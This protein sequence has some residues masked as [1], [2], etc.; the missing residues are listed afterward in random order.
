MLEAEIDYEGEDE[1]DE[2]GSEVGLEGEGGEGGDIR[3]KVEGERVLK[4]GY[5]DKKGE[6]RKVSFVSLPSHGC[7]QGEAREREKTSAAGRRHFVGAPLFSPC[8]TS[9]HVYTHPYYPTSVVLSFNSL[10]PP[11]SSTSP[12]FPSC[13]GAT[14]DRFRP[15]PKLARPMLGDVL[16]GGR[17]SGS[18]GVEGSLYGRRMTR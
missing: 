4:S 11:F 16:L 15:S 1:E 2:D 17:R 18:R 9:R 7:H 13:L 3:R 5:L 8:K 12:S 6:K 10:R 14:I